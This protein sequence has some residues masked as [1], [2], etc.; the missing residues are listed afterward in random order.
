MAAAIGWA[1]GG[2]ADVL[3]AG[4]CRMQGRILQCCSA[5]GGPRFS[6]NSSTGVEMTDQGACLWV[7]GLL[8]LLQPGGLFLLLCCAWME[9]VTIEYDDM[10]KRR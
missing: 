2:E 7:G 10:S 6:W 3:G 9:N 4:G 1:A 5:A 8:P